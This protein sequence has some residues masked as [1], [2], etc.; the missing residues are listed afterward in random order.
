MNHQNAVVS[1]GTLLLGSGI[2]F[3]QSSSEAFTLLEATI[4]DVHAAMS[5]RKLTCRELVRGYLDRIEAYDKKGPHLNAVQTINPRA[6]EEADRLDAARERGAGLVGPLHCIPVLLKDQVETSDMPTTYGSAV[7]ADFVPS[8]DATI[9]TKLKS[10]GAIILAKTTMGEFA[11]RYVGSA[12][13]V[14]RNP[15]DPTRSAGG[16]SGGSG[17]GVAAN[18]GMIAIGEDTGGSIRNPAAVQNLVG[19]RPTVPLVSR[20]GMMPAK[21]ANDTLG[22]ITRTV[23]DAAIVLDVIA[24]YDPNDPMTAYAVGQIPDTY[25]AFLRNDGLQGTRLGVI[26]DPMDAKTDTASEDYR[27]VRTV[28]DAAVR[29]L[30]SFGAEIVEAVVIPDI[31]QKMVQMYDENNYETEEAMNRYLAMHENAPVKTLREILLT[32]KVTPWRAASLL[33]AVGKSTNDT[34]YLPI[35]HAKEELRRTVLKLM[36]DLE[37]DALVYA[38]SDHQTTVIAA[39]VLTNA[40]TE[41]AYGVGSNRRLSPVIGFPA[42]TVPA[43]LTVDGLPVGLELMARPFTEGMLLQ[44][45]YA[46]EQRTKHRRPPSTT[47]A[48]SARAR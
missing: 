47:P 41:D 17:A 27:K 25:T 8:R 4:A 14:V 32:G 5:A 38:T 34:A 2:T 45:A 36:A 18:F 24:G 13:G 12:F 42:I 43:G 20:F 46:F 40:K 1:V 26:R 33:N 19:L 29:D 30:H 44:Y 39:D 37:L 6:L 16:S 9:V 10:A 48:L 23:E 35:L 3:A 15:Y 22:P 7:F 28:I 21:P 11:W 31:R